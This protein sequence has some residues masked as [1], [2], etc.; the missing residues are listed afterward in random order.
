MSKCILMLYALRI[1]YSATL[2]PGST[3]TNLIPAC[4]RVHA[5]ILRAVSPPHGYLCGLDLVDVVYGMESGV[6]GKL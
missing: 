5:Y 4:S 6:L 3:Y 1:I 2:K